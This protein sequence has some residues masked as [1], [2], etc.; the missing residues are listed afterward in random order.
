V[1]TVGGLEQ[2]LVQFRS[3]C[4]RFLRSV[5]RT[6][7]IF[8]FDIFLQ[9]DNFDNCGYEDDTK[10]ASAEPLRLVGYCKF[11]PLGILLLV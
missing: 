8:R 1:R 9:R 11:A 10:F 7:A 6:A 4:C 2:L 3:S 5:Y